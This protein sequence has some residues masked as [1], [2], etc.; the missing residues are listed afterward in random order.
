M[1]DLIIG[2]A[3]VAQTTTPGGQVTPPATPPAQTTVPPTP[4][5]QG[6][7]TATANAAAAQTFTSQITNQLLPNPLNLYW[8]PTYHFKLFM[9]GDEFTLSNTTNYQSLVGQIN[10]NSIKQVIIAETGVTGY[11]IKDV[12][13]DTVNA[14]NGYTKEQ[15]ATVI[16]IT[17][18]EPLGISFLDAIFEGSAYLRIFDYTKVNY[19][20][21]LTFTGYDSSDAQTGTDGSYAG[22][23]I[24]LKAPF[25]N[26]GQWL[27]SLKFNKIEVKL[28]EGGGVYKLYLTSTEAE[29]VIYED[30]IIST[31]TDGL[32]VEGATLGAMFNDFAQKLTDKWKEKFP[33]P[34]GKTLMKFQIVTHPIPW[35]G[36]QDPKDFSMINTEPDKSSI[37][38]LAL[39][40]TGSKGTPTAHVGPSTTVNEF[41]SSAIKS[42]EQGQ[43]LIVDDPTPQSPDVSGGQATPTGN[44]RTS[45]LFSIEPVIDNVAIDP[46]TGNYGKVITIHVIPHMSQTAILDPAQRDDAKSP[47]VQRAM[48]T[49]L[50]TNGFL[51]KEYD[52]VFTGLNTEVIDF[53]IDFTLAWQPMS[54]KLGGARA[55]ALNETVNM[56]YDPN[57]TVAPHADVPPPDMTATNISPVVLSPNG[58]TGRVYIEDILN[59]NNQGQGVVLPVSFWPHYADIE[60]EMAKSL[61]GQWHPAQ[62]I[63]ATV[64][65]QVF[66]NTMTT[67]FQRIE[68]TIRGDPYWLGMSNLERRIVLSGNGST[69]D[70]AN[71][72]DFSSGNPA[73]IL[74]FQYPLQIGDD[75]KP[76]LKNSVV[77]NGIYEAYRVKHSFSEGTFKQTV[78][79]NRYPLMNLSLA[80]STAPTLNTD[81]SSPL[82]PNNNQSG[83][84]GT[85]SAGG[86]TPG[87]GSSTIA[88]TGSLPNSQQLQNLSQES[89]NFWISNGYSPAG[90]AAMVSQEEAE[91][92]FGTAPGTNVPGV[93]AGNFQWNP[94][95]EAAIQAA[96]GIDVSSPTTTHTQQ[97]Q[98]ALWEQTQGPFQSVGSQL[99]T[100]TDPGAAGVLATTKYEIPANTQAQAQIRGGRAA[101]WGQQYGATST[102]TAS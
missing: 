43:K 37:H 53:N 58:S 16:T 24:P 89:Y 100:A 90:A 33:D 25:K 4:Q 87:T 1:G 20:L 70:T 69:N 13:I 23:P 30:K 6:T 74:K 92:Q 5:S 29:S 84:Q 22:N 98:A 71:I 56:R 45:T 62:P 55:Q 94:Q 17:I 10:G 66:A 78:F 39:D 91:S 80:S 32:T 63:A 73:F 40:S 49:A 52:Y 36:G 93:Q 88:P 3:A 67:S 64:F 60:G 59:S 28:N 96:T 83:T 7:S 57:A 79:A 35:L 14:Q 101:F 86:S 68:L 97:L 76:I 2:S 42:T 47:A 81:G 85:P 11:N 18:T 54:P 44:V 82:L 46:K 77:F 41:I 61:T 65:A 48:I 9:A 72:P 12:E 19:F 27:W 95:R 50:M 26:G 51:K 75:F 15:K 8:Q 34:S 21:M 99:M 38:A 31:M 102:L